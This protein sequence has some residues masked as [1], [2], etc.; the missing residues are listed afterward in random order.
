MGVLAA[1]LGIMALVGAFTAYQP[2]AQP[3]DR[4]LF[5]VCAFLFAGVGLLAWFLFKI[6]KL[7][8]LPSSLRTLEK[9]PFRVKEIT[10]IDLPKA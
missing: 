1:L 3:A 9:R 6:A 5:I 2:D 7:L 10:W 4:T 8:R